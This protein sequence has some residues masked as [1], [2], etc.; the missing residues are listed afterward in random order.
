M[1]QVV[2]GVSPGMNLNG[3]NYETTVNYSWKSL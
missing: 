2:K 1:R 3:E